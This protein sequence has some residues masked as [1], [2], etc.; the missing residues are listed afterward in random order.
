MKRSRGEVLG[1]LRALVSLQQDARRELASV[2]R[3]EYRLITAIDDRARK[4]DPLL[5]ELTD[6]FV[7][8]EMETL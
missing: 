4:I 5:D 8:E 1:E 6:L 7:A 2:Q 3:H